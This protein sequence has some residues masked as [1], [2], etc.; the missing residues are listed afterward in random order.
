MFDYQQ[1]VDDLAELKSHRIV[2]KIAYIF[3]NLILIKIAAPRQRRQRVDPPK[4]DCDRPYHIE[5]IP[6]RMSTRVAHR[7][8]EDLKSAGMLNYLKKFE[9]PKASVRSHDDYFDEFEWF[10]ETID[11]NEEQQIAI[12]NIVNCTSFPSPYIIF[13]GPGT[14]KHFHKHT[15]E[16]I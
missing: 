4:I 5:F 6:N 16:L 11:D 15:S 2:A 1:Y 14:G 9:M 10:N 8:L 13:G 7:A 3:D 12:Q